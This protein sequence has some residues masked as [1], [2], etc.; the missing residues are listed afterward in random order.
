MKE[1]GEM[2]QSAE[3]QNQQDAIVSAF[4]FENSNGWYMYSE[5]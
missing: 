4:G 5:K 3:V 2:F 1:E